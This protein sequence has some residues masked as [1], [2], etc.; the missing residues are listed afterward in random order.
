MFALLRNFSKIVSAVEASPAEMLGSELA[1][2][3]DEYSRAIE[4]IQGQNWAM[5]ELELRRC[6]EIIDK[7]GHYGESSYNFILSRL[8]LVQRAQ[9]KSLKDP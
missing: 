4:L 2:S 8:A 5:A 1:Q 6:L 3:L 9:S 7:A